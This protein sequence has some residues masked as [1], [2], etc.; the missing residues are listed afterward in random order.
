MA[1]VTNNLLNALYPHRQ[2]YPSFLPVFL[3]GVLGLP[4]NPTMEEKELR[5]FVSANRFVYEAAEKKYKDVDDVVKN[6]EKSFRF[7][8]YYFPS[9][10]V[11]KVITLVGPIDAMA[12]M[13]NGDYSTDF[14]GRDF[15]GISL[16]FYLGAN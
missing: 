3:G 16:Q 11:P 9:Y 13:E 7:V 5:R 4:N 1:I 12:K 14:L 10:T 15:L 8:K 6:L 2:K